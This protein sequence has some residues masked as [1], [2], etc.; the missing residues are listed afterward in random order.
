[1]VVGPRARRGIDH[2]EH[3]GQPRRFD[4]CIRNEND[5]QSHILEAQRAALAIASLVFACLSVFF[6]PFAFFAVVCGHSALKEIRQ[7]SSLGGEGLA[8]A[9]LIVGYVFLMPFFIL[10]AA[11]LAAAC[12]AI[13]TRYGP[14]P[15]L[16]SPAA[17][18][19]QTPLLVLATLFLV[20]VVAYFA[21]P[22]FRRFLA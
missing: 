14:P 1:M 4:E 19:L 10:V 18:A 2:V 17:H 22:L 21:L 13:Y 6:C 5:R 11:Y 9:G 7:D 16:N 8:T 3:R 15:G 12:I 20:V